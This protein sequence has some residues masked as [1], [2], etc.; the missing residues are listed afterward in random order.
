ER[1]PNPSFPWHWAHLFIAA[2][3]ALD[4]ALLQHRRPLV[5]CLRSGVQ[6]S[7]PNVNRRVKKGFNCISC[8]THRRDEAIIRQNENPARALRRLNR[9][10]S[11]EPSCASWRATVE[12]STWERNTMGAPKVP[13]WKS[14]RHSRLEVSDHRRLGS[15]D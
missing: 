6:S 13:H 15:R 3:H 12:G 4:A 8:G 1:T 11:R 10:G 9:A 14:Q 5:S 7:R 2:S